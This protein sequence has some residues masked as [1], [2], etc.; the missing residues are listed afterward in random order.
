MKY[1]IVEV[2]SNKEALGCSDLHIEDTETGEVM[3]ADQ[4]KIWEDDQESLEEMFQAV[5]NGEW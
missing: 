4:V 1:Q 2:E 3:I 5:K